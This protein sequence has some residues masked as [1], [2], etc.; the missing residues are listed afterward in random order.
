MHKMVAQLPDNKPVVFV[1]GAFAH[2]KIDAPWVSQ[3]WVFQA[4]AGSKSP[5]RC[6]SMRGRAK[7]PVQASAVI[8]HTCQGQWGG[9]PL[10][11]QI[12]GVAPL[13][14]GATLS[15]PL[16]LPPAQVDKEISISEYPLSAAYCLARITNAFEQ[17]WDIT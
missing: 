5:F 13:Q 4:E 2:G 8:G 3:E 17:K 15:L 16:L 1:V 14:P 12:V 6:A 9:V 11:L 10:Q 7:G